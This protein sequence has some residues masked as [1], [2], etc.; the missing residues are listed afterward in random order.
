MAML[1]ELRVIW[2]DTRTIINQ[3]VVATVLV[4]II[5]QLD[6]RLALADNERGGRNLA[7][8]E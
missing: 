1:N 2:D 7:L 6:G 3:V 4:I 8:T 5:N